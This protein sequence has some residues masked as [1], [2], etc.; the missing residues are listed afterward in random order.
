[1]FRISVETGFRAS[2]QLTFPNGSKEQ[3]H[4]HDWV[5]VAVV[6]REELDEV[7]LVMDFNLLK[8][9]IDKITSEF[10]DTLDSG[11]FSRQNSSAE[12]V[13]KCIYEKLRSG[14]PVS[15][16]LDCVKVTEQPGCS[17]EYSE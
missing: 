10:G 8:S 4:V 11:D 7:G 5:V 3:L 2:H 15:V 17:G 12:L 9:D 14:L 16:K 1:M 13:A 6:S